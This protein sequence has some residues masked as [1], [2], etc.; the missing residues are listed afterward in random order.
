MIMGISCHLQGLVRRNAF[1]EILVTIHPATTFCRYGMVLK[2]CAH[3]YNNI[4]TQMIPCQKPM[5]LADAVEFEKVCSRIHVTL[6][7]LNICF[8]SMTHLPQHIKA[9]TEAAVTGPRHVGHI[10]M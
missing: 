5:M 4:G 10:P 8:C 6:V 1:L 3:F 9:K 2:Q 7:N